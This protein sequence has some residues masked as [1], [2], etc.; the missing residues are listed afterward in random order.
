MDL[1]SATASLCNVTVE[2]YPFELTRLSY[3]TFRR[4][5]CFLEDCQPNLKTYH[6]QLICNLGR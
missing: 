5:K 6:F 1:G 4:L 3:I 2:N